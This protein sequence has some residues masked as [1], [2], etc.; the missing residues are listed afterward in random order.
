MENVK[1]LEMLK[2]IKA[3]I[4]CEDV[5]AAKQYVQLEI[6]NLMGIAQ[7]RCKNTRYFFFGG[8]CK[9]CSNLNCESNESRL[10]NDLMNNNFIQL[11]KFII[12]ENKKR[13]KVIEY[14]EKSKF[15]L[16]N[17]TLEESLDYSDGITLVDGKNRKITVY[18]DD[19]YAKVLVIYDDLKKND[20][21]IE[22]MINDLWYDYCCDAEYIQQKAY[23]GRRKNGNIYYERFTEKEHKK[24][25]S[26]I[27]YDEENEKYNIIEYLKE[28]TEYMEKLMNEME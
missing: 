11:S 9:Y 12:D 16:E 2:R 25:H 3:C 10:E 23:L 5:D 21:E 6:D 1:V 8:Y 26:S 27:D 19:K 22:V 4:I 15:K 20:L 7:E 24:V 18:Y 14:L 28:E 13:N 17:F